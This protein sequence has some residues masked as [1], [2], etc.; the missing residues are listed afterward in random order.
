MI[1]T[2]PLAHTKH[3]LNGSIRM[4][5]KKEV[6]KLVKGEKIDG[7]IQEWIRHSGKCCAIG[8]L[9]LSNECV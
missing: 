8:F 4:I 2:Y 7:N 9:H 1:V 3:P 6:H 5:A